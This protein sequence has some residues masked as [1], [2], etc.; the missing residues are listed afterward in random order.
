[1]RIR[2]VPRRRTRLNSVHASQMP[3]FG[4]KGRKKGCTAVL[5]AVATAA[6]SKPPYLQKGIPL[7]PTHHDIG[8]LLSAL[9][10]SGSRA[11]HFPQLLSGSGFRTKSDESFRPA[12]GVRT[13]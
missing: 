12:V 3:D 1:M 6:G 2:E 5:R 13:G 9:F 7:R 10:E 11:S 8:V 4:H